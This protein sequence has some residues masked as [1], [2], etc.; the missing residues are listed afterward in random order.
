MNHSCPLCS[1]KSK[2][3]FYDRK[4]SYYQCIDCSSIFVDPLC[5]LNPHDEKERY[6]K[7]SNDW[8]DEGYRSFVNPIVDAVRSKFS[9]YHK[10]LDFGAGHTPIIAKAL[11][12][13]GFNVTPYD[14]FFHNYPEL[15]RKKY[16]FITCC[17]VIEHFHKPFNEF[18]LL[19]KMLNIGGELI[20]MTY[21]YSESINFEEWYYKND[22]T[23]V[24]FY[25]RKAFEFIKS[26]FNFSEFFIDDRLI[27]FRV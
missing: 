1:G 10:G 15:L 17:E 23:H 19:R 21:V 9:S 18:D 25:H 5:F 11:N 24:F 12:E 14:P 6:L 13:I 4:R 27:R 3:F 7:H 20:C 16:D 26:R 22:S 2:H 8:Q